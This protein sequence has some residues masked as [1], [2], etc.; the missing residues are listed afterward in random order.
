MLP[1]FSIRSYDNV[2]KS[3][4]V[5]ALQELEPD[6]IVEQIFDIYFCPNDSNKF[7]VHRDRMCRFFGEYLLQTGTTFDLSEFMSMWTQ[8]MP[9]A[10][11]DEEGFQPEISY[12]KGL[13][14][15][16]KALFKLESF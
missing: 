14:L 6:F 15:V 2:I 8:S 13:A 7:R 9:E 1:Y 16:R 5:K 3:D 4:T 12:L 11:N 10:E